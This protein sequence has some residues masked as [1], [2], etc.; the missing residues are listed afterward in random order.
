M[1]PTVVL[2]PTRARTTA[3]PVTVRRERTSKVLPPPA[4]TR[5]V[6]VRGVK[7]FRQSVTQS[8]TVGVCGLSGTRY[9][10]RH[11][12]A[13]CTAGAR[14]RR[15]ARRRIP[16]GI[17]LG[18]WQGGPGRAIL[19]CRQQGQGRSLSTCELQVQCA[20]CSVAGAADCAG[21][22]E[23]TQIQGHDPAWAQR[24]VDAWSQAVN[25]SGLKEVCVRV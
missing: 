2:L 14:Q 13:A 15:R 18:C 1:Q 24:P 12:G 5:V 21:F 8:G 11:Q 9:H 20:P 4:P 19:V 3:L 25:C 22:E 7:V 17:L 10:Q 16:Y 23:G 6:K